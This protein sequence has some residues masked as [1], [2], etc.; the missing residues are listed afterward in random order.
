MTFGAF[1]SAKRKELR[2]TL[3]ETAKHLGIAC[4][5]LSDVEQSRRPAPE[6]DFVERI[7]RYLDLS[8]TDHERLLDLAAKSH[9]N[10]ISADLPE[11]IMQRISFVQHFVFPKD[12]NATGTRN[13][14]HS[15]SK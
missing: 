12:V 3:R 1:I 11:Y 8:K 4:G 14:R 7:S 13:G 15:L 5:Y 10:G 6:G 9:R 2:L